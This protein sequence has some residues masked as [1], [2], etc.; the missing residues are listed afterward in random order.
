MLT[1]ALNQYKQATPAQ[2]KTWA[3]NY[4]SAI[5][6]TSINF[7]NGTPIVPKANDGPV[8]ILVNNELSLAQNGAIDAALLAQ[9]P[10]YGTNYTKPLLFI[11]D[12]NY[13]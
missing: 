11:E 8:P 5:S 7:K 10:F 2:Q 1:K 4:V 6:N 9:T 13:D 12:G 3:N